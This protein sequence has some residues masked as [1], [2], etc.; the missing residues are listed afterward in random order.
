M[1]KTLALD[2]K[3]C[4]IRKKTDDRKEIIEYD[5]DLLPLYS[6]NLDTI[7]DEVGDNDVE[8]GLKVKMSSEDFESLLEIL[9][10]CGEVIGM[11]LSLK[12][13]EQDD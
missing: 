5:K 8:V 12:L 3:N 4:E 13:V 9:A 6:R 7:L 2:F 10:G 11:N 1:K